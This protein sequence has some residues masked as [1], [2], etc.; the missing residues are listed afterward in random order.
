M[1]PPDSGAFLQRDELGSHLKAE[2]ANVETGRGQLVFADRV[3]LG[4]TGL[5]GIE[6]QLDFFR[7]GVFFAGFLVEGV[8]VTGLEIHVIGLARDFADALVVADVGTEDG[9]FDHGVAPL[10]RFLLNCNGVTNLQTVTNVVTKRSVTKM[11][12]DVNQNNRVH[13]LIDAAAEICGSAYKLSKHIGYSR[14]EVS[15]WRTDKRACPLEAQVFMA[16]IVGMD[17]DVVMREALIERH[18]NTPRGEKLISALGKGLMSAGVVALITV[19]A[20]D[21]SASSSIAAVELLRCILC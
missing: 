14:N 17:V 15:G 18:A 12:T 6:G 4:H 16:Q 10:M 8:G 5:I 7:V 20:S 21:V 2:L 9:D 1:V 13:A 3:D 11:H 19:S